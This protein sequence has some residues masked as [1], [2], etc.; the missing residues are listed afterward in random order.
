MLYRQAE[1][2]SNKNEKKKKTTYNHF[3]SKHLQSF[4]FSWADLL[5]KG[6]S[7]VEHNPIHF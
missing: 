6:R 1:K 4:K 7:I 5:M 3:L 2:N